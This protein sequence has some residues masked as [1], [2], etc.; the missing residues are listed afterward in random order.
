VG[1]IKKKN[2]L[3]LEIRK[4]LKGSDEEKNRLVQVK[5]NNLELAP[6]D[7]KERQEEYGRT[8][9]RSV[10]RSL[11]DTKGATEK[12][13]P[14]REGKKESGLLLPFREFQEENV[15]PW[16]SSPTP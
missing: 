11:S 13:N 6:L 3:P 16:K 10:Y 14:R 1:T 8:P 7:F 2:P 9:K 15:Y 4:R 5:S 12:K